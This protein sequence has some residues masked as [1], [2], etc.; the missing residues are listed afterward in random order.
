[1]RKMQRLHGLSQAFW[2]EFQAR[3]LKCRC[4]GVHTPEGIRIFARLLTAAIPGEYRAVV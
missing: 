3:E 4:R 1:M 2:Q